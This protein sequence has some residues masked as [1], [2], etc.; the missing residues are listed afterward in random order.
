MQL[1]NILTLLLLPL[2]FAAPSAPAPQLPAPRG[3][4]KYIGTY[5]TTLVDSS[6]NETLGGSAGAPRR[7]VAQAFYPISRAS[8]NSLSLSPYAPALTLSLLETN[9]A[10]PNGTLSGLLTNSFVESAPHPKGKGL[11]PLIF[12]GGFGNIRALYTTYYEQLASEGYFVVAIDHPYDAGIVE[13]P[14]GGAPAYS[15]IPNVTVDVVETYLKVRSADARFVA[16]Q[17]KKF[18]TSG[19]LD[20]D[21]MG[22]FGHSLG[23]AAAAGAMVKPS[24]IKAGINLDGSIY[25]YNTTS[26]TY[27]GKKF[28]IVGTSAH[29][30]TSVDEY[31]WGSF[32]KAQEGWVKEIAMQGFEHL[33][34]GDIGTVAV[35]LGL[36]KQLP[37]GTLDPAIG[38][39]DVERARIIV[40]EYVK[41]FFEFALEGK[42]EGLVKGPN[43]KFPEAVFI[44]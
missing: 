16:G 21:K 1:T 39:V 11:I 31:T 19:V 13:F 23:G 34:F 6:R 17:L 15:T 40:E 18:C 8:A 5:T 25:L 20:T 36:D 26:V 10:I 38:T 24:L 32:K 9:F 43:K 35:L 28:L 4:H 33:T 27:S 41:A 30:S 7:I 44:Q 37:P 3:P 12:S 22:M 42:K 29:N 14:D 2:A